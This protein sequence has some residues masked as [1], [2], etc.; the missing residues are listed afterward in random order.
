DG[1]A[2]LCSPL[3]EEEFFDGEQ[4]RFRVFFEQLVLPFL[5]GQEYYSRKGK[6]PWDEYSHGATGLLES[7]ADGTFRG[8]EI[9]R[10]LELLAGDSSWPKIRRV[11][12]QHTVGGTGP[13]FC[14]N[15]RPLWKCH[16]RAFEGLRRLHS[17]IKRWKIPLLQVPSV[18][19][20]QLY[21]SLLPGR[22]GAGFVRPEQVG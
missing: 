22:N 17:D 8:D 10:I 1:I 2:C 4:L 5:Y 19:D 7:V 11:L 9:S 18:K 14:K 21:N 16:P 20:S 15:G 12:S 13:C 6:W 3:I